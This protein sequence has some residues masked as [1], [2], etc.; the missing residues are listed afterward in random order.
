MR[1]AWWN[2]TPSACSYTWTSLVKPGWLT[3]HQAV[4][5]ALS[6]RFSRDSGLR[7]QQTD[8]RLTREPRVYA[9]LLGVV[10]G[11]WEWVPTSGADT[12]ITHTR[13]TSGPFGK[14]STW[15]AAQVCTYPFL[16]PSLHKDP[17]PQSRVHTPFLHNHLV[18][19]LWQLS[20]LAL[21]LICKATHDPHPRQL[22][23][24]LF[25]LDFCLLFPHRFML[26]ETMS[27]FVPDIYPQNIGLVLGETTVVFVLGGLLL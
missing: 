1:H 17:V 8:W 11:E 4:D 20:P 24:Y 2:C 16:S 25:K 3:K 18:E 14:N 23:Y 15:R 19:L 13:T 5:F 6:S 7:F 26:F 12:P 10:G 27:L 22:F 21:P 9:F